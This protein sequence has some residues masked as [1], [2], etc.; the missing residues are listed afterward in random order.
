MPSAEAQA[1]FP[2]IDPMGP[3]LKT[4]LKEQLGL[5]FD[6]SRGP[7][8]VIVIERVARPTPN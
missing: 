1:E 6:Q 8:D 2:R 7:V 3:S 5:D 4:A